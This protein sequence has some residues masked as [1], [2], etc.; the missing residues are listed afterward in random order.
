MGRRYCS[1]FRRYQD[2]EIHIKRQ[3][4]SKDEAG[5]TLKYEIS[6]CEKEGELWYRFPSDQEESISYEVAD[7]VIVTL[8]PYA[9]RG[10]YNIYS[11]IPMSERL[12][13]QLTQQV[14]PQLALTPDEIWNTELHVPLCTPS[15]TP[16]L[17]AT[18][19]SCGVDSF[20]TF[21]EL[22]RD[23]PEEAWK[24]N[25]LTFF[26]NGAHHSGTI[27][28]SEKEKAVY[29]EQ[30]AHVRRFCKSIHYPLLDV[31]S[32]LDEFLNSM[33][34]VDSYHYTHSY[35]NAGFVLLLQKKIRV[36]YYS[37]ARDINS[38]SVSLWDDPEHYEK[39][40]LPNL[41]TA[42][43]RF[44]ST[45][46]SLNRI[47][48]TR[49][50]AQFS[51]TYDHLL[52]CYAGGENCGKCEKCVRQLLILDHLDLLEPYKSSIPL[53]EYLRNKAFYERRLLAL[54]R[55]DPFLKEVYQIAKKKGVRFSIWKRMDAACY[56]IKLLWKGL[57]RELSKRMHTSKN[58]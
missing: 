34:W 43:T 55:K 38:F 57:K 40:L 24:I 12:W 15:Y 49:Y 56:R 42:C 44:F 28:H 22:T 16:N 21:F 31:S 52:V 51:E 37:G 26:Q 35:R 19:M 3:E 48:K 30:L 11:E 41:S 33:F 18:A 27:G 5:I 14:I 1:G 58:R 7:A 46:T 47:D 45:S 9:L 13:F 17:V 39:W 2:A 50:I 54:R 6:V 10:G 20:A 8:L 25:L 29:E 4:L 32:N 23:M 36:Y 53:G